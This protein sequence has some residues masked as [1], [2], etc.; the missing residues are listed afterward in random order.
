MT[1]ALLCESVE[2]DTKIDAF[3]RLMRAKTTLRAVLAD[4]VDVRLSPQLMET[5]RNAVCAGICFFKE[6][7]LDSWRVEALKS[8][9][10][11]TS[12]T[13]CI[14]GRTT[15]LGFNAARVQFNLSD[16]EC[17]GLGF[18]GDLDRRVGFADEQYL[19][20]LWEA[21]AEHSDIV[22]G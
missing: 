2:Q 3:E 8:G 1:T 5:C 11:M 21:A 20:K 19:G 22:L 12:N 7:G 6:E 17:Q 18:L 15:G 4:I 9:F 14:F 13:H 16:E 10:N